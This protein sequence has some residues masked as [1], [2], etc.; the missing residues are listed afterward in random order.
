MKKSTDIVKNK[1]IDAALHFF[2]I[3]TVNVDLQTMTAR[4]ILSSLNHA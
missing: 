2:S 4:K 3:S 1:A